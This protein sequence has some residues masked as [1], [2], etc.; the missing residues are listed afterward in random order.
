MKNKLWRLLTIKKSIKLGG[1]NIKI[2]YPYT[3]KERSDSNGIYVIEQMTIYVANKDAMGN[4][5][6]KSVILEV[7]IHEIYHAICHIYTGTV[8]LIDEDKHDAVSQGWYQF[9]EDA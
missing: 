8:T 9:F 4:K 1:H 2:V 6:P 5:L 3:F 7:F